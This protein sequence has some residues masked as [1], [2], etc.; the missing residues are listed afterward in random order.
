MLSLS[1]VITELFFKP[2]LK[3]DKKT[4]VKQLVT[5]IGCTSQQCP[6]KYLENQKQLVHSC[7]FAVLSLCAS[8]VSV[9]FGNPKLK[10]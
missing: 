5:N 1:C 6:D 8:V 10:L 7:A 3:M 2:D 4:L 9:P